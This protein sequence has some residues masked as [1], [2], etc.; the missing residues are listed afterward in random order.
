M[1]RWLLFL[2]DPL[3]FPVPSASGQTFADP[4]SREAS[5]QS[6]ATFTVRWPVYRFPDNPALIGDHPNK[7]LNSACA[8]AVTGLEPSLFSTHFVDAFN[9]GHRR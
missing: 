6:S 9:V 4:V 5:S 1:K 2:M 3:A 7:G 8:E